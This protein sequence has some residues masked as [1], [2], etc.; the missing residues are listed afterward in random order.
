MLL[1]LGLETA[2]QR[3]AVGGRSG[4]SREHL[5]VIQTADLLRLV[6]DDGLAERDLPVAGQNDLAI[7]PNGQHGRGVSLWHEGPGPPV[8]VISSAGES[9]WEVRIRIVVPRHRIGQATPRGVRCE[10]ANGETS[11]R[12][13]RSSG[14][15]RNPVVRRMSR[16]R[17]GA[18]G[19]R[20]A[21]VVVSDHALSCGESHD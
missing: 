9:S 4:E 14:Y 5:V 18:R 20:V 12:A 13:V 19:R 17:H 6:L 11:G 1:E 15:N 3:K 10:T 21:E 2:E 16:R 8:P 7:V